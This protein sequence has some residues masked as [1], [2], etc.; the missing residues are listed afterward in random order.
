LTAFGGAAYTARTGQVLLLLLLTTLG[1]QGRADGSRDPAYL[2]AAAE[3]R[4]GHREAS[5]R[6]IRQWP[7]SR[8][9]AGIQALHDDAERWHR[10]PVEAGETVRLPVGIDARAVEAAALMHVE[11][12]L[13]DLQALAPARA[14]IH[15]SAA[16]SLVEWL[17]GQEAARRRLLEVLRHRPASLGERGRARSEALDRA[18]SVELTIS[19]RPFYAALAAATLALGFPETALPFAETAAAAGPPDGEALLLN[20]CVKE[21]LALGEMA[22]AHE[23][24]ARQLRREAETLLREAITA[25][26]TLTEARLRLGGVLLAQERPLEAEAVLQQSGEAPERRQR[27]LALLLLGRASELKGNP[28]GGA[29]FYRRALEVWPQSQAARLGLARC[30]EASA[31]PRAARPLV[32]A[33]LLDSR[34]VG[35]E[36]DPWWSYPFGHRD[37][38]KVMVERLWQGTLGRSFGS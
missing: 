34:R 10:V 4:T 11:A 5:L 20:A 35:R 25:A 23:G 33:T 30:L 2:L 12:G 24:K 15:F 19:R 3:Y 8:I 22:R 28:D 16:T 31:G 27:Y 36:P 9:W 6:E 32:T 13:L 37:L 7:R 18:L 29:G 14:K 26:P 38:A 21:G 17:Q 1:A